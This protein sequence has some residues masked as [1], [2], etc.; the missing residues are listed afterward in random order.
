MGD[1]TDRP[2]VHRLASDST[3]HGEISTTIIEAIAEAEGV[4]PLSHDVG[5]RD[6]V[7]PDALDRLFEP[8]GGGE[9]LRGL[10]V[11]EVRDYVVAAFA[12]GDVIVYGSD[13]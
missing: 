11:F 8:R 5:L 4:S 1:S 6:A 2:T 12:S 10:V 9:P 13:V 3:V 7:D